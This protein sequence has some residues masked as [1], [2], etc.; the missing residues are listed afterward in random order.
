[1]TTDI[2]DFENRFDTMYY[3]SIYPD[4]QRATTGLNFNDKRQFLL[5]HYLRHGIAE[6]RRY[7]LIP[8]YNSRNNQVVIDFDR[9]VEYGIPT[10]VS[11]QTS[12]TYKI[13]KSLKSPHRKINDVFDQQ[14]FGDCLPVISYESETD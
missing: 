5:T 12:H 8:V 1:M 13:S 11:P 7:R 2:K 9:V 4:L 6:K 14:L 10:K 3:S